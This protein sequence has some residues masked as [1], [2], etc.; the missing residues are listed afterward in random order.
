[1]NTTAETTEEEDPHYLWLLDFPD[2]LSGQHNMSVK[3]LCENDDW[4]T[5]LVV[6]PM[7]GFRT[8]KMNAL[9]TECQTQEAI[10]RA[11]IMDYYLN[12]QDA[13]GA[14]YRWFHLKSVR[15]LLAIR[16]KE[17]QSNFRD[18]LLRFMQLFYDDAGFRIERCTRY[19]LEGNSGAKLAATRHWERGDFID[20]LVGT[21]GEMTEGEEGTFLKRGVNDF[22]VMWST[23]KKVAQLWLGPGS[24][25]NHD[26]DPNCRFVPKGPS[27]I[28]EVL[29]EI[30]PGEEL[31]CFYGKNFFGDNNECCE[32][33]T[34]ERRKTGTFWDGVSRLPWTFGTLLDDGTEEYA[35]YR[36]R[37]TD[38][39]MTRAAE[40]PRVLTKRIRREAS[41]PALATTANAPSISPQQTGV[42]PAGKQPR[43][44]VGRPR[45]NP[46][47][48]SPASSCFDAEGDASE[49]QA[50]ETRRTTRKRRVDYVE[51]KRFGSHKRKRKVREINES[52]TSVEVTSPV[53]KKGRGR[54]RKVCL[55]LPETEPSEAEMTCGESMDVSAPLPK[56]KRGRKP[57]HS[58]QNL[59]SSTPTEPTSN[60]ESQDF[61]NSLRAASTVH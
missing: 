20:T 36:F 21:L 61:V 33:C 35:R 29:R 50:V 31:T 23:R 9:R 18:H 13:A 54:P 59:G 14:L 58:Q 3:E 34:C 25:I 38:S 2:R 26:C 4:A 8:H 45:K 10:E 49:T 41:A 27:A 40:P 6:D 46:V 11:K 7:L 51:S 28:L 39:R 37:E 56:K 52:A 47:Q 32:C 1:M 55:P 48:V 53:V 15:R 22:S 44:K 17:G 19:S 42:Q 30:Q 57:K 24:Y 60:A 43:R 12:F 16:T 5:A